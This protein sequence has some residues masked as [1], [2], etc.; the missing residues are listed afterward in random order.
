MTAR[1]Q[2]SMRPAH[3]DAEA[4]GLAV[5]RGAFETPEDFAT[6][7]RT[8]RGFPRRGH[9]APHRFVR[10]FPVPP[11]AA[12]GR[13]LW[14]ARHAGAAAPTRDIVRG[15]THGKDLRSV[16]LMCGEFDLAPSCAENL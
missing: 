12:G 3:A 10:L 13:I 14:P 9:A 6:G 11:M 16:G 8:R 7:T 15:N 4:G 5:G 2:N 1:C